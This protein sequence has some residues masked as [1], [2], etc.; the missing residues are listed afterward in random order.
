MGAVSGLNGYV[1]VGSCTVSALTDCDLT[2]GSPNEEFFTVGGAG[3]S[4]TVATSNRG[5]GTLN[6]V[7]DDAALFSSVAESGELVTVV[8]YSKT[9]GDSATG[10]VRLSQFNTTMNMEG[11]VEKVSV[12]FMTHGA[13]TGTLIT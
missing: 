3:N 13:M 1:T 10:Q 7:L 6:L 2:W 4:L 8:F 9:G 11:T 12:P 5:S